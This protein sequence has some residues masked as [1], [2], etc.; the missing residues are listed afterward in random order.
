MELDVKS[1]QEK[2]KGSTVSAGPYYFKDASACNAWIATLDGDT[3][4]G[5]IRYLFDAR[6]Q[7]GEVSSPEKTEGDTLSD[8]VNAKKA[9]V[10]RICLLFRI[11]YPDLSEVDKHVP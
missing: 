1:L 11:T 6:Q 4:E 8:E 9:A 3:Q 2:K 5:F 7:L 10:A